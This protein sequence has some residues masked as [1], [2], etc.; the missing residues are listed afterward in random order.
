RLPGPRGAPRPTDAHVDG[1]S[2]LLLAKGRHPE[3]MG[4]IIG[5]RDDLVPGH[6]ARAGEARPRVA[7]IGR[8]ACND[9]TGA[10][11][12]EKE[13]HGGPIH[14]VTAFSYL[15]ASVHIVAQQPWSFESS[16]QLVLRLFCWRA[17]PVAQYLRQVIEAVLSG[18]VRWIPAVRE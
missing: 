17:D 9:G 8:M 12:S 6:P 2:P 3:F 13:R 1:R 5:P 14:T 18:Q 10:A 11:G 7:T 16:G 4:P 15:G